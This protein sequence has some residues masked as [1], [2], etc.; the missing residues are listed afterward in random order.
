MSQLPSGNCVLDSG[1]CSQLFS[2][3]RELEGQRTQE[4][5][6]I[7]SLHQLKTVQSPWRSDPS[8]WRLDLFNYGILRVFQVFLNH[9]SILLDHVNQTSMP[10]GSRLGEGRP[11]RSLPGVSLVVLL[12]AGFRIEK[13][14]DRS[15]KIRAEPLHRSTETP[16]SFAN[17]PD[18]TV[19]LFVHSCGPSAEHCDLIASSA[20]G[21]V[22]CHFIVAKLGP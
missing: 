9:M 7:L 15:M 4:M 22:L 10:V 19:K 11:H 16:N 20:L 2:S 12:S 13:G 3:Q 17:V 5:T 8:S 1:R 6:C 18:L 14:W 21:S